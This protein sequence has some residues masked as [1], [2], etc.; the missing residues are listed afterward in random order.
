MNQLSQSDLEL[1]VKILGWL[2]IVGSGIFILIGGFILLFLPT[3]GAASE[4]P[5]ALVVLGILAPILCFVFALFALPGLVTGIGLLK[6]AA[7][8]RV[9]ALVLAVFKLFN[10]PLGTAVGAYTFWVLMQ[11]EASPFFADQ[12]LS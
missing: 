8:S 6:R 11:E 4:D 9:A 12:K 1:H 5:D 10:F 2:N 3:I 7:W